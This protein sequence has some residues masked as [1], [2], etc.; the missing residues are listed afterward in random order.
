MALEKIGGAS[1]NVERFSRM[2][3]NRYV[4]TPE[5]LLA[6]KLAK[7]LGDEKHKALYL[8]LCK[9][10]QTRLIEEALS[11]VSDAQARDKGKLFLWK[12]KQLRQE[13][14]EAGRDPRRVIKERKKLAVKSA[15]AQP[16]LFD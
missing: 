7:Q 8:R 2:D 3:V 14:Q 11:F 15:G 9:Y 12:V 16:K 1:F 10:V 13:W 6:L 4:S 5:Q